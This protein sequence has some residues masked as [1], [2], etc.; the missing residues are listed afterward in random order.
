MSATSAINP[1]AGAIASWLA[2]TAASDATGPSQSDLQPA[3]ASSSSADPVDTISLSERAQQILAR[4]N[5]EQRVADKLSALL[6]SLR[7]PD[8]EPAP[9]LGKS[10]NGSSLFR[11]LSGQASS[12]S[13]FIQWEAGSKYGDPAISDAD[14]LTKYRPGP[15]SY[16]EGLSPEQR[17]AFETAISNGT[18]QFQKA[19]EV[20]GLNYRSTVTYTGSPGGL[21][22]MTVTHQSSAPTGAAKDAIDHGRAYVFWTEDRGDV[23]VTW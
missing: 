16:A 1:A 20:D 10:G 7:N 12:K 11:Q 4:A 2:N 8:G 18:L 14:F 17:Q 23:Y 6:Q 21:Q 19:S 22:G 9:A 15:E 13:G 5:S 3:A